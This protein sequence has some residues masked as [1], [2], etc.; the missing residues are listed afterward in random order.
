MQRGL[1]DRRSGPK[2][3]HVEVPDDRGVVVGA[4]VY[5]DLAV[6][7]VGVDMVKR[8]AGIGLEGTRGLT[9]RPIDERQTGSALGLPAKILDVGRPLRGIAIGLT[10]NGNSTSTSHRFVSPNE[11]M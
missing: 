1:R 4:Y 11:C 2:I 7:L 8:K 6:L 5:H 10:T 3:L 9:G